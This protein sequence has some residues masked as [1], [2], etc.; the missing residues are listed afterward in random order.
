MRSQHMMAYFKKAV[1][2]ACGELEGEDLCVLG[3]HTGKDTEL[4]EGLL[5]R[6]K[7]ML[8]GYLKHQS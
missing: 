2:V 3:T 7:K 1:M 5:D 4:D 8:L 6:V